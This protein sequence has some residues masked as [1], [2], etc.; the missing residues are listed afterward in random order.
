MIQGIIDRFEENYAVVVFDNGD[1]LN[2]SIEELPDDTEEGSV[3]YFHPSRA[4]DA[5][6]E[7]TEL[8]KA[9]LNNIL[10]KPTS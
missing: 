5:Q 8:A 6:I 9:I 7:K 10:K 3:I 4:A 2:V 1:V